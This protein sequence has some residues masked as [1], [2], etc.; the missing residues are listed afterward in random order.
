MLQV[1]YE[2][3]KTLLEFFV[4]FFYELFAIRNDKCVKI[5]D[6]Y[7]WMNRN[8][9]LGGWTFKW[10]IKPIIQFLLLW[11]IRNTLKIYWAH[12]HLKIFIEYFIFWGWACTTNSSHHSCNYHVTWKWKELS[13]NFFYSFI[14][15]LQFIKNIF[16]ILNYFWSP[17]FI[18][19]STLFC[20]WPFKHFFNLFFNRRRAMQE[21]KSKRTT[22]NR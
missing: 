11:L 15:F 17:F 20:F 3:Q 12:V 7:I 10:M 6:F 8:Y 16:H 22:R 19:L 21:A 18:T 9:T 4:W 5:Y 2:W 1:V 14:V 13:S